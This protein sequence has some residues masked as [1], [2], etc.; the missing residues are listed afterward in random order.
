M[1][2]RDFRTIALGVVSSAAILALLYWASGQ[3]PLALAAMAVY[4]L[5][6]VSRPRARRLF[7]RMSGKGASA[8]AYFREESDSYMASQAAAQAGPRTLPPK[9][10]MP[11]PR[12]VD[13]DAA[14]PRDRDGEP[15]RTETSA[16]SNT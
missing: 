6:L 5:W 3:W 11:A 15:A 10:S 9:R 2:G 1:N 4:D 16:T 8:D 7:R 13:G 12:T 14:A